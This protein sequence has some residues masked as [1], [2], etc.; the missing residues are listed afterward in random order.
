MKTEIYLSAVGIVT[1]CLLA[2]ILFS[3]VFFEMSE[4]V[5]GAFRMLSILAEY[6]FIVASPYLVYMAIRKPKVPNA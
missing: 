5:I 3:L 1:I 4:W 6:F 2:Y